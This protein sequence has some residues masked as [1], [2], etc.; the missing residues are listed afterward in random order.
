VLLAIYPAGVD[1]LPLRSPAHHHTLLTA[2]DVAGPV[3]RRRTHSPPP[4]ISR[5]PIPENA[6]A[7]DRPC[8]RRTATHREAQ[9]DTGGESE[10][11]RT[12]RRRDRRRLTA[13]SLFRDSRGQTEARQ[14]TSIAPFLDPIKRS[15]FRFLRLATLTHSLAPATSRICFRPPV[16]ASAA[17]SARSQL[18]RP[19][20]AKALAF[21][22]TENKTRRQPLCFFVSLAHRIPN[23]VISNRRTN[24]TLMAA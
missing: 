8:T 24:I 1:G 18:R 20:R 9:V 4:L 19:T 11:P 10:D 6:F 5:T 13:A 16:A 22:Y 15:S 14:Q 23:Q 17:R 2:T 3:N 7:L 12:R 21:L